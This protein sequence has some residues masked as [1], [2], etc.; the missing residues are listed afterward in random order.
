M[1]GLTSA[2]V[3]LAAKHD[4]RVN[5][6]DDSVFLNLGELSVKEHRKEVKRLHREGTV[7]KTVRGSP[8]DQDVP[9]RNHRTRKRASIN[10]G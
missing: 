5:E 8:I 4:V 10:R 3:T 2:F 7:G 9:V 1:D 6:K